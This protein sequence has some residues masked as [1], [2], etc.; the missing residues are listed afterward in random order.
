MAT[1]DLTVGSDGE[2]MLAVGRWSKDKLFYIGRYCDI[3]SGGM[4]EKWP[5]R[6]YI[7][8][9]AGPGMCLVQTTKKE[10]KGSPLLALSCSVPFSHYFFNDI[11]PDIIKSLKVRTAAHSS[12]VIEYFNKDCNVVVDEL[13]QK[14]PLGSLDFCFIDPFN[15]E[16]SFDSI[17]KLTEN[18]RMDLAVTFHIGNIKR[19]ADNP[20]R[21]L[22]RFFP[23]ANWQQ[24]YARAGEDGRLTGRVLLDA[25]ERGLRSL[26]YKEIKDYTLAVNV[27]NVP[28][29]HLI[30][31]SKHRRGAD[32]WDKI[33]GRSA[34]GQLR[35]PMVRERGDRREYD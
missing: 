3:F 22:L 32:F 12:V 28:L 8:L 13:L 4:K 7:D 15:W 14:L 33:A 19:V 5:N 35:M 2:L 27:K 23:D 21:E 24:E 34:A 18:R 11:D 1:G 29:Y 16:I 20:P 9:F 6:T 25:Y 26:G 31:A 17:R 10:I 30:F